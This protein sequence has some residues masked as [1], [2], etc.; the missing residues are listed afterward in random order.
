MTLRAKTL[1]IIG[2][3]TICLI[4]FPYFRL[5]AILHLSVASL[6][7]E[8]A[9]EDLTRTY[10]LI[11]ADLARLSAM[12]ID[13]AQWDAT[14]YYLAGKD[15]S[16]PGSNV[17]PETLRDLAINVMLFSDTSGK[18]R[19]E[20]AYGLADAKTVPVPK[21]LEELSR[22]RGAACAGVS[23]PATSS[24]ILMVDGK[25]MLLACSAVLKSDMTGPSMGSLIV[26]S[27]LEETQLIR[28]AAKLGEPVE[29]Y[30][31]DDP[32][33]PLQLRGLVANANMEP[34]TYKLLDDDY[35]AVY[36][37][38]PDFLNKQMLIVQVNSR[39]EAYRQSRVNSLSFILSLL[40]TVMLFGLLTMLLL[41]HLIL[42]RV[43]R[44]TKWVSA[45]ASR[46][47]FS[48]SISI[49]GHDEI[50]A[51]ARETNSMLSSLEELHIALGENEERYRTLI[52]RQGEG[53]SSV[54]DNEVFTYANPIANAIFGVA[55]ASLVGRNL[56]EF[57]SGES[58]AR[59]S[60]QSEL[61]RKGEKTTYQLEIVRPDGHSRQILITATPWFNEDGTYGGAL[62]IFRDE[63]IRIRAE[64]GMR[65]MEAM[66][67]KFFDGASHELKTPLTATLGMVET[68]LRGAGDA[69]TQAKFLQRIR[70]QTLRMSSLIEDLL[71]LS[72]LE[73]AEDVLHLE[74]IDLGETVQDSLDAFRDAAAVKGI[75]L[76]VEM[77]CNQFFGFAD[78][79]ALQMM[80]GNL[81]DN[82]I[83]YTPSGGTVSVSCSKEERHVLIEVADTGIGIDPSELER[84]FDRFY[85][86]D[87]ARSRELGGTG[88]GL[89]IVKELAELQDGSVSVQSEPGKGSVFILRIPTIQKF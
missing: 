25:P 35:M 24:G 78:R 67:R 30:P 33:A 10:S 70:E 64:A 82:A 74:E 68:L 11:D 88:L 51:L 55:P 66:R 31:A 18:L 72:R 4:V 86:V 34:D 17:I 87:K 43:S 85:R 71:T 50:S 44:L 9:R 84:I 45:V 46:G 1:L 27:Y 79:E 37:V 39:R 26:G 77:D 36:G 23:K 6:E 75:S 8:A 16:Y 49:S 59:I 54:D 57:A 81:L 21:M 58:W 73:S 53:I 48:E 65:E 15:P 52:E 56:R 60:A 69:E 19:L 7:K 83:K 14:Y 13:W 2:L 61:R 89:S 40:P 47:S 22:E 42:S 38:T 32:K 3:S 12:A 63:T 29:I 20:M 76:N 80:V 62:A 28:I 41:E 5:Q